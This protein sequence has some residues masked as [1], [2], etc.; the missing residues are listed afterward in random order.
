M[1]RRKQLPAGWTRA[2]AEAWGREKSATLYAVAAGIQRPTWLI[3][4]VVAR[5]VAERAPQLKHGAGVER[6]IEAWR[7]WWRGRR[8]EALPE[9]R[10][11]YMADQLGALAP[12]TIRNRIAYLRSACRWAWKNY[13]AC[14][15]DPGGRVQVPVVRNERDV[16]ITR[17]Q[18]V[19][20]AR[21][22][23]HRGVRALIRLAY[24]SGWR[25]GELQRAERIDGMLVLTDSKNRQPRILPI[26]G[27][28]LAASR[29]PMPRRS[30][31]DYYWPLARAACGLEHVH[32]HDI[33]HTLASELVSAGEDLHTVGAVL[34]HKS[35]Q[36]TK[37]YA[38]YATRRLAQALKKV[39]G[40]G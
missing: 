14:E 6:E 16:T 29:V 7:D 32:L 28:A 38:H 37:R 2:Q 36:S 39:G 3:E 9:A 40:A 35:T 15:Q 33:R 1:H 4:D 30:E 13:N 26:H 25:V 24:Y 8:I 34:G 19:R 22:C 27:K 23:R 17:L 12:A 10:A 11:E 20:L 21:A 31:I 5:W 18:M